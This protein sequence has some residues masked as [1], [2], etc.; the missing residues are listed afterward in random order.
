MRCGPLAPKGRRS[1]KRNVLLAAFLLASQPAPPPRA[2]ANVRASARVLKPVRV[3]AGRAE[4]GDLV[5]L[6][7]RPRS[8]LIEFQ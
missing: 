4:A 6:S 2:T 1:I 8:V 7:S 3:Q 5:Q